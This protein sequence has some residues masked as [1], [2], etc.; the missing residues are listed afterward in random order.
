[1][2]WPQALFISDVT[3]LKEFISVNKINWGQLT[4]Y[5]SKDTFPIFNLLESY[6]GNTL[7]EKAYRAIH[8]DTYCKCGNKTIFYNWKR[9]YGQFCSNKCAIQF[10]DWNKAVEKTRKTSIERHGGVGL[11]S[12][13]I[14]AKVQKTNIEKYGHISPAT[15]PAVKKKKEEEMIKRY[16][17]S[18]PYKSPDIAAKGGA[19]KKFNTWKNSILKLEGEYAYIDD[20]PL[21]SN[22][23]RKWKHINC[24]KE[25]I[26]NWALKQRTPICRK[27]LP[28]IKG[29]SK[30][31]DEISQ[32]L[33]KNIEIERNKRFYFGN[34]YYELDIFMPQLNLGIEYNGL[35][36]H[37]EKAGK[38]RYYHL[39]KMNFFNER[40]IKVLFIFE[41]EWHR[42]KNICISMINNSVGNTENKIYARKC[43]IKEIDKKQANDF[44]NKNH[45]SGN[46]SSTI[47]IGLFYNNELISVGTFKKSRY[48]KN[49]S[50]ELIRFCSLCNYSVVGGLS[51][52]VS[53][54]QNKYKMN[55]VSYCNLRHGNGNG[56]LKAGF[57]LVKR[58]DPGYWYFDKDDVYHRS[59]FQKKKLQQITNK[60][61]TEAELAQLVGLNRFWDCGNLLF[62]K[63]YEATNHI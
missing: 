37:S 33:P 38:D 62:E 34:R 63:K 15:S 12:P 3:A 20:R 61:G 54:F 18:V 17:V 39:N 8:G 48:T 29:T 6:R 23:D 26:H 16:G 49:D 35:F 10:T 32:V 56:Y 14:K 11:S 7:G 44:I 55:V 40:G 24:G 52:I 46:A 53:F 9:G 58:T 36:W 22:E 51:K 1:M 47:Q 41:H 2:N 5:K 28:M 27:C 45:V 60:T 19:K 21:V 25:F 13:K 42:N 30:F 57:K 50:F 31:E 43:Q 59:V 4:K